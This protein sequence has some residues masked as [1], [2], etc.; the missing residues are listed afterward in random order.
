MDRCSYSISGSEKV[1]HHFGVPLPRFFFQHRELLEECLHNVFR[2]PDEMR[3]EVVDIVP[4]FSQIT[5]AHLKALLR[6]DLEDSHY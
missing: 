5:H 4:C 3:L 2:N 6:N 1:L